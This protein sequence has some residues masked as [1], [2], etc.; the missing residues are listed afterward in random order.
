MGK[1]SEQTLLQGR[2]TED[3][4]TYERMLNIISLL[5]CKLKPQGDTTSHWSEWPSLINQQKIAGDDVYKRE[6]WFIF[7][8]NEDW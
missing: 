1:G 5:K 6:P 2:H 3:P 7:G 8:G 4:K